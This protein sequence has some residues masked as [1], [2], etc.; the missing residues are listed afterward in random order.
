MKRRKKSPLKRDFKKEVTSLT[1]G[2]SSYTN[3]SA[4]K[5]RHLCQN[6]KYSSLST[7]FMGKT[8][9]IS[10]ST[11]SRFKNGHVP[12]LHSEYKTGPNDKI[13]EEIQNQT[14]DRLKERRKCGCHVDLNI[15]KNIIH[16]IAPDFKVSYSTIRRFLISNGWKRRKAQV[17][18]PSQLSS[19]REKL[20]I[21]FREKVQHVI[22]E[23]HLKSSQ[24]HIV[25]ES[26]ILSDYIPF[27][28]YISPEEKDPYVVGNPNPKRDT[29]IVTLTA[30][31]GGHLFYIKHRNRDVREDCNGNKVLKDDGVKGVG[32]NE[33]IEWSKSFVKY[34]K[35]GDLLLLDNLHAHKHPEVIQFLQEN[36]IEILFF[37]VRCADTLSVLDNSFFFFIIKKRT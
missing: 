9:K 16:E 17:R 4:K 26:A 25:D 33:F 34:A 2:L 30:N 28:T 1:Y 23:K 20:I 29:I 24:L 35:P 8:L 11:V 5:I 7:R 36:G 32:I 19:D 18:H 12:K 3:T 27:Y 13:P 21:N 6:P 14:I 15:T 31:G 37:P 22:N 10:K